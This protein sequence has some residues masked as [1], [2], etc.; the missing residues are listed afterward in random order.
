M[1]GL[2]DAS[3]IDPGPSARVEPR[4]SI[5]EYG[6]NLLD[7]VKRLRADGATV[8]VATPNPM[9]SRYPYASFGWYK[10]RAINEALDR[11]VAEARRVCLTGGIELVDVYAAYK[12]WKGFEASLPDGVHPDAEGHRFIADLL[13]KTC[14]DHVRRWVTRY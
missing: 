14:R 10:G 6:K 12:K 1:A 11:Y 8:I 3:Y 4:I 5:E 7:I 9:T 13:M 2:N